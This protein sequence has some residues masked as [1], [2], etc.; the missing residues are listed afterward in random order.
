MNVLVLDDD[1]NR[2][3]RFRRGLLNH[4]VTTATN[5]KEAIAQLQSHDW[6]VVFLDHDLGGTG[7]PEPS[8]PGTGWEV[9]KWLQDNP[10]HIPPHVIVHSFN[11]AGAKNMCA[12]LPDA[13]YRPGI[14]AKLE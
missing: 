7:Q 1:N 8:G 11:P 9:A 13:E 5:A 10:K 14:W 3:V 12:C 4:N 6:D 2:L